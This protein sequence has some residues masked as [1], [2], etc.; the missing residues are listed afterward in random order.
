MSGKSLEGL[1]DHAQDW[2]TRAEA[3]ILK[4]GWSITDENRPYVIQMT[5]M[6]LLHMDEL[7]TKGAVKLQRRNCYVVH[8]QDEDWRY[9]STDRSVVYQKFKWELV[10]AK[11]VGMFHW[12]DK[13]NCIR[14]Y[15]SDNYTLT[16]DY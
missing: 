11:R 15:A 13:G 8:S 5:S 12:D 2:A 14:L 1:I 4:N 7:L 9:Q 10:C 6:Y 3:F 16:R